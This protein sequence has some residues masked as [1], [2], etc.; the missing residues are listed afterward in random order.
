MTPHHFLFSPSRGPASV[1]SHR[2]ER[3]PNKKGKEFVKFVDG[4][5]NVAGKYAPRATATKLVVPA[6]ADPHGL[7]AEVLAVQQPQKSFRHSFDPLKYILFRRFITF[8][9]IFSAHPDRALGIASIGVMTAKFARHAATL[10]GR[11]PSLPTLQSLSP[12]PPA[13]H[14]AS[15][16]APVGARQRS[17]PCIASRLLLFGAPHTADVS[18]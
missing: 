5:A 4:L 10:R 7:L 3:S 2:V 6:L 13:F 14:L 11:R 1:L 9:I 17:W 15:C 18:L 16:P 8:C 12:P